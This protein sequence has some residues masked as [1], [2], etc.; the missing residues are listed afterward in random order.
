MPVIT[1]AKIRDARNDLLTA[2]SILEWAETGDEVDR[3]KLVGR[4]AKAI[5]A[6]MRSLGRE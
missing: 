5:G 2:V 3:E 1:N 6:G 4:A